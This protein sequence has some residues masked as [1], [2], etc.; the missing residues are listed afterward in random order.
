V[1]KDSARRE[2]R[3]ALEAC[4]ASATSEEADPFTVACALDWL[5]Y[6]WLMAHRE[7]PDSAAIPIP[8]GQESDAEMFVQTAGASVRA[9]ARID[10]GLLSPNCTD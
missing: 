6:D 10:P 7:D 9:R 2:H 8:K 4:V 5:V 1:N 3:E